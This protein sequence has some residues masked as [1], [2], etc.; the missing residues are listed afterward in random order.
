MQ[1]EPL[2]LTPMN[3]V[4]RI[5]DGQKRRFEKIPPGVK[6]EIAKKVPCSRNTVNNV[7]KQKDT[8]GKPGGKGMQVVEWAEKFLSGAWKP[9]E[10]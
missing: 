4:Q 9:K 1:N 6:D 8:I 10:G 2:A 5:T 7:L 3:N